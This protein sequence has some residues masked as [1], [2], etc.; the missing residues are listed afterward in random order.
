MTNKEIIDV[1]SKAEYDEDGLCTNV[2]YR[3]KGNPPYSTTVQPTWDFNSYE[4]RI[5][6]I[7][8]IVDLTKEDLD[9]RIRNNQTLAIKFKGDVL[10]W[11][12]YDD[13]GIR[14]FLFPA[15]SQ[16]IKYS[17][18]KEYQWADGTNCHKEIDE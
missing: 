8:R 15:S 17:K 3:R 4:Y 14:V 10:N 12:S 16:P 5:K 6:P 18:L 2:M 11:E 13:F 9:M 1:I 7:K